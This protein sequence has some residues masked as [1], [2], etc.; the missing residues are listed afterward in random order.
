MILVGPSWCLL[1]FC[2]PVCSRRLCLSTGGRDHWLHR[3][4]QTWLTIKIDLVTQEVSKVRRSPQIVSFFAPC[5]QSDWKCLCLLSC[6]TWRRRP[7][8]SY[9]WHWSNWDWPSAGRLR[10]TLASSTPLRLSSRSW[11][12]SFLFRSREPL[13]SSLILKHPRDSGPEARLRS[14]HRWSLR[15]C[16]EFNLARIGQAS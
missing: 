6:E 13:I 14:F 12:P 8:G 1:C 7:A 16:Q 10:T 15:M 9:W 11:S 2:D 3:P 5:L 4:L